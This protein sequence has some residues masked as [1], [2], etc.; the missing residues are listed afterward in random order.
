[1]AESP[2]PPDA[3][4]V[5][6]SITSDGKAIDDTIGIAS[7]EVTK[8][9][10]RIPTA[11]I[12]AF[13]GDMPERTFPLSSSDVF[14]PGAAIVIGAG[15]GSGGD[16]ETIF[17]GVVVSH[18][19][20]IRGDGA[21][22]LVVECRDKAV[23]MTI[24][25]NNAHYVD[26]KDSDLIPELV[27][28]YSGLS[29]VVDSTDTTYKE[30]VQYYCTDWD[31]LVTRAEAAG[32]IV[33]VEAG[34]VTAKA[35]DT[36]TAAALKV[37]YGADLMEFHAETDA[38][39]QLSSVTA[40]S[41]DAT[42]QQVVENSAGPTTLNQ[43]GNLDGA[44]LA[45]VVGPTSFRLQSAAPLDS[46]ALSSWAKAQQ[47]KSGLARIQ[48]RMRF[49]GSALAAV[50]TLIELEGVG[51]RFEGSVFVTGVEHRL[52]DGAWT[53][54][55]DFGMPSTWFAERT[56]VVAPPASG[57]VPGIEGLQIGV[58][59]KLD[60]SPDGEPKI[61]V[62]LPVLQAEPPGVWA[63]LASFHATSGAGAFF[64][65]EVGDEVL[66]GFLANDPSNPVV[67]GSLY[68]SKRATPRPLTA[69]NE[70]K[71]VVTPAKLEIEFDDENKVVT[72]KT[73]GGN[74]VVLSD[75]DKSITLQ[76][77]NGNKVELGSS[78][79]L[80]DSPKDVTLKATGKVTIQATSNIELTATG[81]VTVQGT[82]VSHK[83][84][85]GFTAQGNATAELS[86]S[87]QTTVK[88]AMVMIN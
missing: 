52:E 47:L 30:L 74:S 36:S 86:A 58:V 5:R 66:V 61:Q 13:D 57:W 29:A 32:L 43:Q 41:W 67:L 39:T 45:S 76:D 35:P 10:N 24:G 62:S 26:K 34:K 70:I 8:R 56:D 42:K 19:I 21:S 14:K 49:Q 18:G 37:T 65:P 77:Q 55:A 78:G 28:K 38:R 17:S 11:R 20:R 25:R 59:L 40:V 31:Y 50:G 79:I 68:S 82:N 87:G 60:A 71:A 23:A 22:R 63:R 72:V 84:N 80:L 9:V 1:M 85:V 81:D 44:T 46:S 3:S 7:V 16:E 15:Y 48:G 75:K 4:V 83:A 73:P 51:D 12:V 64:V 2:L 88:G 54:D 27:G 6:L 53:T 69:K 33:V